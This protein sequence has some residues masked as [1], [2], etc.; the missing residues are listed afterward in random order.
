[1]SVALEGWVLFA[2]SIVIAAAVGV[3]L[4]SKR[5]RRER[6]DLE[7]CKAQ[8]EAI[9]A[10]VRLGKLGEAEADSARLALLARVRPSSLVLGQNFRGAAVTLILPTA[11]FLLIAAIVAAFSDSGQPPE[12]IASGDTASS[13]FLGTGADDALLAR[14]TS[15]A[16]S[17]EAEEPASVRTGG[18]LLPDVNTMIQRLAARLESASD[19]VNGWQMLGWSYFHTGRYEQAATAFLRAVELDPT[20]AELKLSYEAAKARASAS[21]SP[22]K[23]SK[24]QTGDGLDDGGGRDVEMPAGLGAKNSLDSDTAIRSMVDGLANRLETSPRDIE[25]WTHL[26]RS[27]VVL[28]ERELAANAFRRALEVFEDDPAASG[29]ITSA[30]TELGLNSE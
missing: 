14:L 3:V 10:Q 24:L 12:A 21:G 20:S 16:S 29:I 8:L 15:Y 30:A 19:D 11:I 5:F 13:S 22:V 6:V 25:G 26:M 4:R 23:N 2:L 9:G 18:E 1:M 27:R 7:A 17:I 28:G